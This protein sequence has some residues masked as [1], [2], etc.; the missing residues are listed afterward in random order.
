M[1]TTFAL[2]I[3]ASPISSSLFADTA[4]FAALPAEHEAMRKEVRLVG[5]P[6]ELAGHKVSIGYHKGVIGVDSLHLTH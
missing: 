3:V 1:K 5:Q 2:L 6:I 4:I